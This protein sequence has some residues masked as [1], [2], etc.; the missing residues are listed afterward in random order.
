M[1]LDEEKIRQV[2]REAR[3]EL[4]PNADPALLK[5]IVLQVIRELERDP[6]ASCHCDSHRGNK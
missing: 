5:K 1:Q 3:R 6:T 2:V 4:G